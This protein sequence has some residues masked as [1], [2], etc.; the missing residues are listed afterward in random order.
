ME[1]GF[2]PGVV[3]ILSGPG[4]TGALLA[5]HMKISKV[6]FTGSVETGIKIQEMALRSNMKR[7]TLEL[8][9]KSPAIVFDD[10]DIPNAVL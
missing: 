10:A 3:Q 1:A 5:K 8:G 9:G 4:S 7:C 2:P 6:S